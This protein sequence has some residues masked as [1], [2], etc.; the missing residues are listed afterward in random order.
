MIDISIALMLVDAG[1]WF[2]V[3][4]GIFQDNYVKNMFSLL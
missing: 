4:S 1:W 3:F 2:Q